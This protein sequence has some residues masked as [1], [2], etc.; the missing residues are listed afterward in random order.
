MFVNEVTAPSPGRKQLVETAPEIFQFKAPTEP[1]YTIDSA[2]TLQQ[3]AATGQAK[4]KTLTFFS[5]SRYTAIMSI[6][7]E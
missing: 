2:M 7:K 1:A 3:P 6:G 5:R 4:Q